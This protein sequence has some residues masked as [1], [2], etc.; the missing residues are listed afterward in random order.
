MNGMIAMDLPRIIAAV[1]VLSSQLKIA[2]ENTGTAFINLAAWK[3]I[4]Y[5]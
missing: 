3:N 5:L 1:F 4:R 2:E